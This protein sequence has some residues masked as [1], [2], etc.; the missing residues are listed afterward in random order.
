M[1]LL[2]YYP[3]RILNS[4]NPNPNQLIVPGVTLLANYNNICNEGILRR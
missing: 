2:D 4:A 1:L 3:I